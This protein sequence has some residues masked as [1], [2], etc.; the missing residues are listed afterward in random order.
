ML[1]ALADFMEI[2]KIADNAVN[3]LGEQSL[4]LVCKIVNERQSFSMKWKK[5]KPTEIVA[6]LE[7]AKF[8]ILHNIHQK[9][10]SIEDIR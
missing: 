8:N 2:D 6:I 7:Q 9:Q 4:C 10:N 1:L 5:F 3:I